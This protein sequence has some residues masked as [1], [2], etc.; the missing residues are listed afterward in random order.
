M[1]ELHASDATMG[2]AISVGTISEVPVLFFGNQLITRFRAYPV[3][4]AAMLISGGRLLL[5][6][7]TRSPQGVLAVQ[8][9]A[10][11]AFP[12]MW[13]AGVAYAH[14]HA[15]AGLAATAQG[16]LGA[17][18]F[19]FG[20]AVGGF[21]GGPLLARLG[22]SGTYLVFGVVVLG[23]VLLVTGAQWLRRARPAMD[24]F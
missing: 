8:L 12:L 23:L 14:E 9:L 1:R 22:G 16:L 5:F 21:A 6:A 24:Q 7:L 18:V 20:G 2:L 15:P 10:G 19:G 13:V 11:L 3:F 4:I 17:M